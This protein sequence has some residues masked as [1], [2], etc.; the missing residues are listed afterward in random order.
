[1]ADIH[2]HGK[3]DQNKNLI[4]WEL[5]NWLKLIENFLMISIFSR[6]NEDVALVYFRVGYDPK[7]YHGEEVQ[8][9]S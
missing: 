5:K 7:D 9:Q 1:M 4:M 2:A 8:K 3:L 6:N